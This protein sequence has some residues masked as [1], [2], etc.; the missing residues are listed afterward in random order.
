PHHE[1]VVGFGRYREVSRHAGTIDHQR[2]IARRLERTVDASE[3]ARALVLDE[4]EF[5][6]HLH[7][8]TY[9]LSAELLADRLVAETHAENRNGGGSLG[10]KI[11]A[12]AGIVRRAGAGR[13]H[14]GLGLA[15]HH[16]ADGYL[17]VPI[18]SHLRAQTTEVVEQVE[19]ETVVVV[20]EDDHCAR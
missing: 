8:R 20:D 3:Y 1:L 15:G 17:V 7:R 13:Q 11:E 16:V 18:H 6:V 4:R 10:D 5:A 9:D 19:G 14:D 12:D 2:V